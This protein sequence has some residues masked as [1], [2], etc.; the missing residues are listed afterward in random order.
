MIHALI[1]KC[2]MRIPRD[3]LIG[4]SILFVRLGNLLWSDIPPNGVTKHQYNKVMTTIKKFL[5]TADIY[6]EKRFL[7]MS[8]QVQVSQQVLLSLH[9]QVWQ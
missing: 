5:K 3:K 6:I 9:C 7:F 8:L 2:G 1:N 4:G